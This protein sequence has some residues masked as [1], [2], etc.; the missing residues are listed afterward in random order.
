MQTIYIISQKVGPLSK[1]NPP[2]LNK[3][4]AKGA[5]LSK[6]YP[7][8]YAVVH[9]VMLGKKHQRSSTV[10]EKELT[11]EGRHHL[12]LLYKQVHDKNHYML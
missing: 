1:L 12:L 9:A 6:I 5:F 11:N 8:I 7:P 4:V 2:P 10:E 3:I